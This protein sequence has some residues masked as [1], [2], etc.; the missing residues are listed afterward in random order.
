MNDHNIRKAINCLTELVTERRR[1]VIDEVSAL[2]TRY[3]TVVLE[4]IYRAQN[5]TAVVRSCECF[6][7]RGSLSADPV[8]EGA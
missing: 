4:D 5:A 6:G 3:V 1:Q 2:R 7:Q 8:R